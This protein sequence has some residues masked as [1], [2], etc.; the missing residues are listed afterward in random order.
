MGFPDS[1]C[2]FFDLIPFLYLLA[3]QGFLFGGEMCG[4][5]HT[6]GT[7]GVGFFPGVLEV[8]LCYSASCMQDFIP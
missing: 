4:W 8:F 1:S 7:W 3:S 2:L 6:R 5:F